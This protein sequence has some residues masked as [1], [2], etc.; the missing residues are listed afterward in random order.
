M[1]I[2]QVAEVCHEVNRAY[3]GSMGDGSQVA[4]GDSPEWQRESAVNGVKAH[5]SGGGLTPQ[6]SHE[7]W[8]AEKVENGWVY[9]PKKDATAKTHPCCV[10]YEYLPREQR[11]KD[12]IFG[13]IVAA[14]LPYM[15]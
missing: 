7:S 5:I 15:D 12:Y 10:A 2:E 14:L 3:C 6:Q 11:A 1:T 9:G 4:W 13:A 8:L